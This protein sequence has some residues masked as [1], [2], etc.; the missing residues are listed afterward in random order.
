MSNREASANGN[1]IQPADGRTNHSGRD[2]GTIHPLTLPQRD[3]WFDQL[4][5][6]VDGGT[7]LYNVGGYIELSGPVDP[8]LFGAALRQVVQRHDALRTVLRPPAAGTDGVPGQCFPERFEFDLPFIDLSGHHDPDGAALAWMR[9][10]FAQPFSLLGGEPLFRWALLKRRDDA[11]CYFGCYHHLIADG[12]TIALLARS[13]AQI[14]TALQ[15]GDE[16]PAGVAPSYTAFIADDREYAGSAAFEA[17]RGYWNDRFRHVPEP[18]LA[19]R[20][21]LAGQPS[22]HGSA[23]SSL[24]LPR[25]F[26]DRLAALARAQGATTFHALLAALC[27][28]FARTGQRDRLVLGLPVLNRSHAA[29]KATAGLFVS[30]TAAQFELAPA[31]GFAGLMRAIGR[32][33][34]QNYR[35]QRFPISLINWQVGGITPDRP[36]LFDVVVSYERHDHE[37]S[38]GSARGV[39]LPLVN[40]DQVHPLLLFV[41]EFRQDEAV[42]LDFAYLRSCFGAADIERLQQRLMVLL[43]AAMQRPDTPVHALPLLPA[44]EL[45]A[46]RGWNATTRPR[47]RGARLLDRYE[48]QVRLRPHAPAVNAGDRSLSYAQLDAEANRLARHLQQRHAV[49]PDVRVGVGLARSVDWVVAL[50]AV[51]KAGGACVPLDPA[52]PAD[53]LR[54]M[55]DDARPAVL[56]THS[57]L[58]GCWPEPWAG[59]SLALDAWACEGAAACAAPADV[60]DEADLACVIY[61]SGSTGRPKGVMVSRGN[62]LHSTLARLEHYAQPVRGFVM[63][64]SFAFDSSVAGIFWTLWQ[65]GQ[66]CIPED[67]L[68]ADPAHVALLVERHAA[69]HLL[70]IPS[71]HA[72]LLEPPLAARLAPLRTVIVAGEACG[73]DLVKRHHATLPGTALFNEYGPTEA[74]VWSSVYACG[75]VDDGEA[76]PIGRPISNVQLHLLDAQLQPVPIG[77]TGEIHISG[78]GL[79]RGYLDAPDLTAERFLPCPFSERPGARMYRTGDLARW[80]P[81]GQLEFLG[82]SDH[83]VKVR[84]HRIELAEVEAAL[85]AQPAVRDAVVQLRDDAPGGPALVAYASV[86]AEAVQ[87]VARSLRDKQVAHWQ[88]LYDSAAA[89]APAPQAGLD[90]SGWN[91]SYTGQPLPEHEMRELT[92]ATVERIRALQPRRVLEIGCGS[93]LLLLQLAPHC[94]RYVGTDLSAGTLA[95]LRHEIE[96]R[97]LHQ[98]SLQHRPAH[99][100]GGLPAQGFD[101]IVINSVI[102]YFPDADYLQQVIDG[103]LRLMCAEGRLFI[104]D[105]RHLGLAHAFHAA[106]QRSRCAP[107]TTVPEMQAAIRRAVALEKELLLAP[108]F[109]TTLPQ[110]CPAVRAVRVQPKLARCINEVSSFR[111]DV[112]LHRDAPAP[113]PRQPKL[114]DWERD[115]LTAASLARQ[116]AEVEVD[117]VLVTGILHPEVAADAAAAAAILQEQ[118][119]LPLHALGLDERLAALR[120]AGLPPHALEDIA[121]AAGLQLELRCT[122]DLP[123]A[124]RYH[125]LLWR[126]RHAGDPARVPDAPWP[127]APKLSDAD[128]DTGANAHASRPLWH[129]AESQ[130]AAALQSALARSLPRPMRPDHLVLLPELPRSPNGKVDRR[131]LPPPLPAQHDQGD[132]DPPTTATEVRLAALWRELLGCAWVGR[133]SSFFDLG[134]HSLLA[135]RLVAR[136]RADWALDLPL[137]TVFDAPQLQALAGRIDATL[138]S[139]AQGPGHGDPPDEPVPAKAPRGGALPLSFA[140]QR[141]WFMDRL[142]PGQAAYNMP[143]AWRLAGPLDVPALQ[144]AL[145]DLVARHEVL[146]TRITVIDGQPAQAIDAEVAVPFSITD[147]STLAPAAQAQEWRR[148]IGSEAGQAFDLGSAPMLRARLL[149]FSEQDH[150]LLLTLH[151][152]AGDG[153]SMAIL[154]RELAAFYNARRLGQRCELAALPL[155]YADFAAWQ[156]RWA[157]CPARDR[158]LAYWQA[159]LAD[160]PAA[161]PLPTD[162]ARPPL[163]SHHGARVEFILPPVLA[164]RVAAMARDRGATVFMVLLA[165]FGALLWRLGG[166]HDLSIGTPIANRRHRDFEP[167]VGCFV[168]TLV[169]RLRLGASMSFAQLVDQVRDTALS[170]YAHQDLPFEQVVDALQVQRDLSRSPLFQVMFALHNTAPADAALDGLVLQPVDEAPVQAKY[171]LSLDMREDTR[172]L[173]GRFE[174]RADLFAPGSIRRLAAHFEVLLNACLSQPQAPI[175]QRE[176]MHPEERTRLLQDFNRSECDFPL[177]RGYAAL[178]AEQVA[179][180]PDRIAARCMDEQLSYRELDERS[181]RIAHALAEAGAGRETLVGVA[182]DRGLGHLAAMIGILKAGAACVPLDPR[183]PVQRLR[184]I[185]ARARLPLLLGTGGGRGLLDALR[186]GLPHT[187]VVLHAEALWL[188]GDA[189]PLPLRSAPD[190]LAYVIFTSGSTGVP[191]GAMVE[192]RSLLNNLYGKVPAIGLGADD[193]VAQTA[194]IGFDI[195]VWQFLAAPLLGG[196]VHVLPDEVAHAPDRLLDALATQQVTVLQLVPSTLRLLLQVPAAAARGPLALRQVLCIGEALPPEL[197][198]AWFERYPSVPLVNIY[199]PAECA[200]NVAFHVLQDAAQAAACAGLASVPIGRPTANNQLYVLDAQLQP[201]PLGVPG[202]ICVA[203]V[204]VGRGYLHE[205]A[206]TAQAFVEHPLAPGGRL[207]RTGDLGRWRPDGGIDYLGRRDHQVKVRGQRVE[208]GE[209]EA[210]LQACAG[211]RDAAAIVRGDVGAEPA[212]VAYWVGDA[213]PGALREALAQV[214]PAFMV[215]AHFVPLERLPLNANGKTDR[216]A[217]AALPWVAL[218]GVAEAFDNAHEGRLSAIW[219]GLLGRRTIGR[220]DNFFHLGGHS[221]LAVQLVSRVR[222]AFAVELPLRAVFEAPTLQ[223]LAARVAACAPLAGAEPPLRPLDRQGPLPLSFAQQRLWFLDR[224]QP[225]QALYHMPVRLNLRG[226]LDTA[227]LHGALNDLVARHEALRTAIEEVAGSPRQRIAAAVELELPL[228]DLSA[229]PVAEREAQADRLAQ[230]EAQQP[231]DLARVPLLRARLLRLAPQRHW[232]LLTLHHIAGDAWSSAILLRELAAFYQ[233][234]CTGVAGVLA[235]LPLQYADFAGWQ[236]RWL[237]GARR[238]HQLAYWRNQL[239]GAPALLDLPT[240]HPRPAVPSRRGDR[241]AFEI[242]APLVQSLRSVGHQG[243]ATLFVVLASAFALLLGRCSNQAEVCLGTPVANRRLPGLEGLVGFFVNTLVLRLRIDAGLPFAHW[244][245]HTRETV[246]AAQ[247]HQDLPFEELVEA[248]QPERHLSHSPLFQVML[249]LEEA[250]PQPLALHQDLLAEPFADQGA[251]PARF[252]LTLHLA[253]QPDGGLRGGFEYSSELFERSTLE[254]WCGHFRTLLEAIV[255][256]PGTAIADLPLLTAAERHQVL[257]AWNRTHESPPQVQAVHQL[258]EACAREHAEA[259]AVVFEEQRLSYAELNARANQL[260]HWLRAQGLQPDD[261]VGLCV[262]PSVEMVIGM[263]GV[264][265]A[266]A[267]YLPLDPALPPERLAWMVAD[268]RPRLLLTQARLAQRLRA[269]GAAMGPPCTALDDS[270]RFAPYPTDDPAPRARGDHLAYV[271]YTSGSTGRPKGTLIHHRG[272][273]NLAVTLGK[274]LAMQPGT[275]VLQWASFNFDA[276]VCDVFATLAAGACL[277]LGTRASLLPGPDLLQTLQRHGIELITLTPSALAE[278]PRQRLPRLK[279]LVVAGEQCDQALIA[280][281]TE[282]CTVVNAYGPTEATVCATIHPCRADGQRHPPIGRPIANT[283]VYILDDRLHPVPVGVMGELCIGGDGLARGYL[284]RPDLTAERFVLNPFSGQPGARMYRTGDL[285]RYLPDGRIEYVGRADQ[286]V[287]LRGYR[288][289]LGEIEFALTQ[290]PGVRE[291][292][293]LAR[294]AP[295]GM[296]LLACVAMEPGAARDTAAMRARLQRS[297]PDYMVPAHVVLLERLP[298]NANGKLDRRALEALPWSG[299]ERAHVAPATPTERRLASLWADMLG[300]DRIGRDDGFFALG[301]HSLLAV[302]LMA[303]IQDV[304]GLALPLSQL[305]LSP[306]LAALAEAIDARAAKGRLVV[307]LRPG[308]PG[309][310]PLWLIHPAGGT[311]FCYRPLAAALPAGWPVHALQS[312][313]VAGM[314]EAPAD[315]ESLCRRYVAEMLGVQPLGPFRLAGWSMGGAIALRCAALLE[316]DGHAVDWVGLFDTRRWTPDSAVPQRFEAF[317]DWVR[318]HFDGA[319]ALGTNG[320]DLDFLKRQHQIQQA[321]VRLMAGFQ[322]GTVRAPLRVFTAQASLPGGASERADQDTRADPAG[323][324]AHTASPGQSSV[325]VLAG[326]HESLMLIEA[327]VARMARVLAGETPVS[328]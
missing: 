181:N 85:L 96:A 294:P 312:A 255:R 12:W 62:L 68:H 23:C 246:L 114:L 162:H 103:A 75:P 209:I 32:E 82:R 223:A 110:R 266:G 245:R 295:A 226:S 182:G 244:L 198:A 297:L 117:A 269:D 258:F 270:D 241:V 3:I 180:G 37:V 284:G 24:A 138:R 100:F 175:A 283:Q 188:H 277:V 315:F 5:H 163:P 137:R 51:L 92:A 94:E 86:R 321:H 290:L 250:A 146:R 155:Q 153:W 187:P 64:S 193:R 260:A 215:P 19:S 236:R 127:P 300:H 217:L 67:G 148:C 43:E 298:V 72:L 8:G 251:A 28:Y 22:R 84:G 34:K 95:R 305:F 303:R 280:P 316:Q 167:L 152:V 112:V 81:D 195:S 130:A 192:Q 301:G 203:G 58:A 46:I 97:G 10:R 225:G 142:S 29:F 221:L 208:L 52:Y 238:E 227:A 211:V 135:A 271:I 42:R 243:Q 44:A 228:D 33:L 201:L 296:R 132:A 150:G 213:D 15:A 40:D 115:G 196:T 287:K 306:S 256:Q 293:V 87:A 257:V 234:R 218:E 224:L 109:F 98:A 49:G 136:L 242:D 299:D 88:L 328:A 129:A 319:Q 235:P 4:R 220:G 48:E 121:R 326:S 309:R 133:D 174:Y 6:A 275:R 229:L 145:D 289:E 26:Y 268:A 327:N 262:E 108:A 212:V 53:R 18:L 202:E 154:R 55:L 35:H 105:V 197:A 27:V 107:D 7:A 264:L 16:P 36:Q 311:V 134:G 222:E 249:A 317:A 219:A 286:Q 176:L 39:A 179:R 164:G 261:V 116:L 89:A 199:G 56:L 302:R 77:V 123:A 247:A 276:A 278:L 70:C 31:Q 90:F 102:Q 259:V 307:P 200:D 126:H 282:F 143:G 190:D 79:A 158:E 279:T 273:V 131:A 318:E 78:G 122:E 252:D 239:A 231:F 263:L 139:A 254:R 125:A 151:H 118:R 267:A 45:Q 165:A 210:R 120:Q 91:S 186:Q 73:A 285:A 149:R 93:G 69:S 171:E 21:P 104:G 232:L 191:K 170:A 265:K 183:H 281:W 61:T 140:Q 291:A 308:D 14:Y 2:P 74:S 128:A 1:A 194:P 172:G 80:R 119:P 177:D 185:V 76:V 66:L 237:E 240:D 159:Q 47:A 57:T 9:Q 166:Q 11:Y 106:V 71:F 50:L 304:F 168:N 184:E 20:G 101:T 13:A 310:T 205:P 253:V 322:P 288:I 248:L 147:V 63:P 25:A 124:G 292:V 17:Q 144:G 83:Q 59:R 38:F 325:Q 189:A 230:A 274:A 233:A 111:F 323:W 320:H 157:A 169:M 60:S 214:L 178:F 173:H 156:R 54:A 204:G 160:A 272:S 314:D 141:L 41:R 99:D 324:L 216:K 313:E 30:V 113:A 207:Y 206:L 65:G 161:L